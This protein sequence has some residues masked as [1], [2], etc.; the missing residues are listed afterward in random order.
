M[1][2]NIS[3][4]LYNIFLTNFPN[5]QG[6]AEISWIFSSL[7]TLVVVT[8]SVEMHFCHFCRHNCYSLADIFQFDKHWVVGEDV[9]MYRLKILFLWFSCIFCQA[10]LVFSLNP[11]SSFII[12]LERRDSCTWWWERFLIKIIL[13]SVSLL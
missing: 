1:N 2:S 10:L 3:Q 13:F 5:S 12:M 11:G 8:A 6:S 7:Y 9:G 4:S